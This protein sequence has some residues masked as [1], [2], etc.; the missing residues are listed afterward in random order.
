MGYSYLFFIQSAC[1]KQDVQTAES[2][3]QEARCGNSLKKKKKESPIILI[4]VQ[5][6]VGSGSGNSVLWDYKVHDFNSEHAC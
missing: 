6:D 1:C 2:L 4:I 3:T 5:R